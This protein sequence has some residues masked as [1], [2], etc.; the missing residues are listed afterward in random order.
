M[1]TRTFGIEDIFRVLILSIPELV[2]HPLLRTQGHGK[3]ANVKER[4]ENCKVEGGNAFGEMDR[5]KLEN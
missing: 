2:G 4:N 1:G 5:E 3:K